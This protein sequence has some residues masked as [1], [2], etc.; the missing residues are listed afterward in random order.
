MVAADI[1]TVVTTH[2]VRNGLNVLKIQQDHYGLYTRYFLTNV[3]TFADSDS[4]SFLHFP[5]HEKFLDCVNRRLIIQTYKVS[6]PTYVKV[7]LFHVSWFKLY[8]EIATTAY[9][10]LSD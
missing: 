1:R 3:P 7:S 8:V 5:P 6:V 9:K 2:R 4:A 10:K